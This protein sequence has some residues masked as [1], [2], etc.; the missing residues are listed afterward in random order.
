[1]SS[2]DGN[3]EITNTELYVPIV[4]LSTEDNVRLIKQLSQEFKRS[5]YWN[6]YKMEIKTKEIDNNSPVR[7]MLDV[8]FQGVKRLFVLAFNG[9]TVNDDNNPINNDNNKLERDSHQKYFLPRVNV[10]DY[11]VIIDGRNFMINLLVI[12]TKHMM[13]LGRFQQEKVMITQQ[14]IC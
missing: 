4:N 2:V 6:Q 11:N 1:M 5:A 14:D 13:R 10:T 9:T 3:T 8:F 12:K 7:I